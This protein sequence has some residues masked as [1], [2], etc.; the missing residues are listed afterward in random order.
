MIFCP[1]LAVEIVESVEPLFFFECSRKARP[2]PQNQKPTWR[3]TRTGAPDFLQ[4]KYKN[5]VHNWSNRMTQIGK[6]TWKWNMMLLEEP[7]EPLKYQSPGYT[8]PPPTQ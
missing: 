1:K 3:S 4:G 7:N 8:L 2:Y 6:W 5:C